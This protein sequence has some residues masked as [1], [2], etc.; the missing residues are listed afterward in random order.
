MSERTEGYVIRWPR[1]RCAPY[2]Y[3]GND[4]NSDRLDESTHI[5][6]LR[7]ASIAILNYADAEIV[8]VRRVECGETWVEISADERNQLRFVN[9]Y[10]TVLQMT[11]DVG[12]ERRTPAAP[13]WEIVEE[14]TS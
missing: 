7:E 1:S 9:Q 2:T 4:R 12:I 5:Y 8:R 3:R 14:A 11:Y 10:R 6:S 13:R